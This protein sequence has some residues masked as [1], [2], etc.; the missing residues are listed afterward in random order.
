MHRSRFWPVLLLFIPL[1]GTA[2]AAH[3]APPTHMLSCGPTAL[4]RALA[5]PPQID[6]GTLPLNA[7]GEH[8][9][10]LSVHRDG[11]GLAER[12]CYRTAVAGVT[13][14][15]A[16]V[17]RVHRGEHFALRIVNDLSAPSAGERVSSAQIPMCM[18]MSMPASPV[19][20]Y[21]GYL[22][23][24]VYD[25]Y[26]AAK[27][28][29]TNI[30]LHGFQGPAMEENV[31]VSTLSTPM[32]A[33]E[34]HITIPQT[35]PL[36]TY[37]YH[38][39]VHGASDEEVASGLSGAWIVEP[40]SVQI[41]RAWEH[42]LIM[43]YQI[44]FENDYNFAPDVTAFVLAEAKHE[45]RKPVAPPIEAYDPFNPPAWPSQTPMRA[46]SMT[47][48]KN[49][50]EGLGSEARI[51]VNGT[52]LPA[53]LNVP[54]DRPQ[55]LRIVNATSDSPKVL[56]LHDAS[57]VVQTLQIVG[58]DGVPVSNDPDHPFVHYL[59][60]KSVMLEPS[61]RVDV[62]VT[63]AAGQ[64]LTLSTEH[65]CEGIDMFFQVHHDLVRIHGDQEPTA[66]Q[67]ALNSSSAD[68]GNTAAARLITFARSH[69]AL[70]RRRALSF[71]EYIFPKAGK[72]PIHESF[73]ITDTT[74]RRFHEHSFWPVYASGTAVP[75]N[76]DITVH[77]GTIEEWYLIN[78][79]LSSHAFHIHQMAFVMENTASGVPMTG[80]V[81]FVPVGKFRP[82]PRDPDYPLIQP[83][84][85]KVLMD[86]RH[87]P[88]GTFVFHCHMLFHE[89][90]GMMS[91]IRVV[92][93][94]CSRVCF[95][96]GM[97]SCWARA[98]YSARTRG[99]MSALNARSSM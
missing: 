46:G 99:S 74:N 88:R 43:R 49:I 56:Q 75:Q 41:P 94:C 29:D 96:A 66:P 78:T 37:F 34:Y 39:H 40:D 33:C 81:V 55:L 85:T 1:A 24:M 30:H 70:I 7:S 32:R 69:P 73:F 62:L 22:N 80:D 12:F 15:D 35:Q 45:A 54:A 60:M 61:G 57:G 5:E 52:G 17:I 13:R 82:N 71:T 92:Y 48:S 27:A 19:M 72:L 10:I 4:R 95:S 20:R 8:E 63:A 59:P 42:V 14:F 58:R 84:I 31:F 11:K 76:A 23:H 25:R 47:L 36:G 44:P 21:S 28:N 89:D 38:P 98:A 9:L 97:C 64:T 90:H 3:R 79:T 93:I 2:P 50:C 67:A 53:A 77:Q 91:I 16:P 86:F 51:T 83:T 68:P 6:V 65:F 18:P 87:V 26:M